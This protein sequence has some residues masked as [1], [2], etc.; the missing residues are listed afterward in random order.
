[1]KVLLFGANGFLGKALTM[2]LRTNNL[3]F[4]TVSR[5]EN[6]DYQI[7]I[8]NFDDFQAI[9]LDYYDVVV[10]AA[11]I[12][13]GGHYLDNNYLNK[14]YKTNILGTQNICKWVDS[15]HS[16][17]KIIN[18]S[19]LAVVTKPWPISVNEDEKTYPLGNHV[20]Y[21]SSKL[22]QE[23]IFKTFADSK[24]I[25]LTQIRFSALY[26]EKMPWAGLICNLI[27]Q[28]R[29]Q[30]QVN[31]TNGKK[32][33]ADFLHVDDA[34]RIV[35]ATIKN[36]K[37]GIINGASGVETQL[38]ELASIIGDKFG[39]TEINNIEDNT[40]AVE[41]AIIN[42]DKLKELMDISGFTSIRDGVQ[43]LMDI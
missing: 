10:N 15:Q 17:V 22:T 23:L 28:A 2:E 20:L 14:I 16:V 21:C 3:E 37:D 13:P 40:R 7:D 42:I 25:K 18:C 12:L 30:K 5:G 34:S 11:T 32:I 35:I 41:H 19:T 36:H 9:P 27:D 8:G 38:Y 33:N 39:D 31:L 6:C 43:G 1:M 24:G 4:G 26:G 29:S